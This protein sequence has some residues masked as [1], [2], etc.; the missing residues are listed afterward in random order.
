MVRVTQV[1]RI[2]TRIREARGAEVG[3]PH[4]YAWVS[5]EAAVEIGGVVPGGAIFELASGNQAG[6]TSIS[7]LVYTDSWS[8]NCH[9]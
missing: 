1:P 2:R 5:V 3:G 7:Q 9:Y 6:G 8:L 4:I